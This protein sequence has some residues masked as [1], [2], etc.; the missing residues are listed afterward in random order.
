MGLENI[1]REVGDCVKVVF[2]NIS[3]LVSSLCRKLGDGPES[4]DGYVDMRT[5]L[6]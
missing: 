1:L 5:M 2:A 4:S 3:G 6:D